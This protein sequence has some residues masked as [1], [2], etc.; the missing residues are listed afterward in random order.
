MPLSEKDALEQTIKDREARIL[1]NRRDRRMRALTS[2]MSALVAIGAAYLAF[3]E[4]LERIN[5]PVNRYEI[6]VGET[7]GGNAIVRIDTHTGDSWILRA[8]PNGEVW[9]RVRS[10]E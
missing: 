9:T 3:L 10:I 8:D 5:A 7:S 6:V 2:L 4:A 1:D